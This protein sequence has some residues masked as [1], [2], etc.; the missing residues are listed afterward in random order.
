MNR[1]EPTAT[2]RAYPARKASDMLFRQELGLASPAEAL[3]R[4]G[5]APTEQELMSKRAEKILLTTRL[6]WAVR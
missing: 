5:D 6:S 1:Q 4:R 3:E 2:P